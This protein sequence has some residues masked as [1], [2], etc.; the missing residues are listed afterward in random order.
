M[1]KVLI[2]GGGL[3]GLAAA[4]ALG[5]AGFEIELF[6]SRPFLGGRA[7][8]YPVPG[9][10]EE[11]AETID[12]CQHVLLRCCVNLLNFYD[13]LGVREHIRFY[14]EFYFI[15]PGGRVSTLRRGRFP[16]PFHFTDSFLGM[17]FLDKTDKLAIARAF[18]ALQRERT[19][20]TDLERI[21]MLDWLLQKRQTPKAIDRFWRQV[22]VSAV[23]EDLDRMAAIHGFQV[24][25]LG[26]LARS[27]SYEMGIPSIPL[28]ELYAPSVLERIGNV[29]VRLR[30]PVDRIAA[31]G[32]TANGDLVSADYYICAL[33]FERLEAAGLPAP[34]LD[35][36]PITG[37]HLWF[38]REIT[39]LPH[40]TL[41]DRTMQ[42]MFNKSGGRYLQLVVSASRDLTGLSRNEIIDIAVGDLRLYF[43][44]VHEARLVKA[45]VVKEQR[46]TFSAAPETESLRCDSVTSIPNVFLAGDWTRTGWPATMEGAVRSGYRAAELVTA[47][48]GAHARF[49]V[50]D[51]E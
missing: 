9:S 41:L 40:A 4:A 48:A 42:W 26:F 21:S 39:T 8:S 5:S 7:T 10:A 43:P 37:V 30:C 50:P 36:S 31:E 23:N 2:A 24:F 34:R 44:K 38:D 49:L 6:E 1:P 19:R 29:R 46:A 3:A 16:A 17:S 25:W 27:D 28:A 20:R 12:N 45:H 14:R 32:F 18:L 47:A 22:L 11:Q 13:R 33:P 51:L 35:H 15:E